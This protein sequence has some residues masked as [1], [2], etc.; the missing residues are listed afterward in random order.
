MLV[1]VADFRETRKYLV[2]VE[3]SKPPYIKPEL[4]AV[5]LFNV[6]FERV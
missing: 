5:K 6:V 3:I 1:L 4:V 2:E